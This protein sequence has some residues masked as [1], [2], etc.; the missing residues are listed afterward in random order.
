MQT[1]FEDCP[2]EIPHEEAQKCFDERINRNAQ[3]RWQRKSRADGEGRKGASK[4]QEGAKEEIGTNG[5]PNGRDQ[6]PFRH[7]E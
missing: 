4:L 1:I 5:S 6:V 2:Y 3:K 7:G